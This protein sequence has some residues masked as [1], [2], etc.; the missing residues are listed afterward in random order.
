MTLASTALM[1]N[2]N[3]PYL[4]YTVKMRHPY[5]FILGVQNSATASVIFLLFSDESAM[6]FIMIWLNSVDCLKLSIL[7]ILKTPQ[8][9][10]LMV[11]G[12]LSSFLFIFE[13]L[14]YV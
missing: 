8:F 1:Y 3:F 10:I 9:Y 7:L 6:A 4:K 5:Y 13:F 12:S 2:L 11:A 14:K